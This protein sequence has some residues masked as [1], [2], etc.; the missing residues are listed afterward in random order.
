M[1][2]SFPFSGKLIAEMDKRGKKKRWQ[3][4]EGKGK[5]A[6]SSLKDVEQ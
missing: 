6:N 5:F 1:T 2:Q 3:F 4:Y